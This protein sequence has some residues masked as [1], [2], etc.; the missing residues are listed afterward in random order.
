MLLRTLVSGIFYALTIGI[1][2]IVSAF[3]VGIREDKRAIHDF[4]AGTEVVHD[5]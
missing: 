2:A 4:I 1:G 3:M 5:S